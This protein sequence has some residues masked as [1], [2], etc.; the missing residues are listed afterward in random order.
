MLKKS[1]QQGRADKRTGGVAPSYVEDAFEVR[2]K[3]GERRVSAR[4]GWAGEN[5]GC[6]SIL[7]VEGERNR[8]K[9]EDK[10][11][12]GNPSDNDPL[13]AQGNMDIVHRRMPETE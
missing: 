2:T 4:R 11:S 5:S 6:F 10:H 1:V 13:S 7:L 8:R 3:P 12:Q 9:R